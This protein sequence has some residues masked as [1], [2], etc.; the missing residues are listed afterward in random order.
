MMQPFRI[1]PIAPVAAYKTYSLSAPPSTHR[2]PARCDEAGCDA[3]QRGWI[4]RCDEVTELGERQAHYIRKLSGRRY[5]EQ[6]TSVGL[7]IFTFE[8]G[9]QCFDTHTVPLDREPIYVVRD[10]DWRGNPS[11]RR[12]VLRAE[13]WLD[14]FGN[15]QLHVAERA[16]RG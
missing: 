3:Y 2:R 7:T 15:H 16:A 14:D 10:G 1:E 4:T 5:T 13:D 9:Q 8:A 6:R 11:G 12:R